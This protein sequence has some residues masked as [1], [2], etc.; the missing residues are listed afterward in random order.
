MT[1]TPHVIT[2]KATL[3]IA[4]R[5]YVYAA[6]SC[7]WEAMARESRREAAA[8]GDEHKDEHR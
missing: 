6:C 3:P 2:I 1:D 8:D 4:G 7:G 5:R